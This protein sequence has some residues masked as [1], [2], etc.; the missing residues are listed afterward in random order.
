[1][2]QNRDIYLIGAGGHAKV[3]LSLL[4]EQDM[5]CLGIYDD[6]NKLWGTS[7]WGIPITGPVESLPD[8]NEITAVISIGDNA[9]RKRISEAY[10]NIHWDTLV[11][12]HSWVHPS[13]SI[14]E[15]T[16]IFAGAVIQPDTTIGVHTIINT[17]ATVDHDCRIGSF[18][19]IAPGCHIAGGVKTGDNVF[20][21]IGTNVI[22]CVSIADNIII[23]ASSAVTSD[24][25]TQGTYIGRPAKLHAQ[26][27]ELHY[28]GM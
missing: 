11:H 9:I 26:R 23:G 4:K 13:V 8:H 10:K 5:Q 18:C 21:G 14:G 22:P 17:S 19:H 28:A 27:N 7:L 25:T 15:G 2:A 3:I 12:T 24:L 6:N 16:V 1:M 20:C